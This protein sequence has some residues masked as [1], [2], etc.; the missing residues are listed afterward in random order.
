[1]TPSRKDGACRNAHTGRHRILLTPDERSVI[2]GRGAPLVPPSRRGRRVP[3]RR[4]RAAAKREPPSSISPSP[5]IHHPS[6]HMT[7]RFPPHLP[8]PAAAHCS[9]TKNLFLLSN[10]P[11]ASKRNCKINN[12]KTQLLNYFCKILIANQEKFSQSP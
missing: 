12:L 7:M 5:A 2:R 10:T 11:F 9:A 3:R 6:I 1:M 4:V 8:F